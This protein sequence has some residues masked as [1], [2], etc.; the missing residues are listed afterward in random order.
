MLQLPESIVEER[1]ISMF[2]GIDWLLV[3]T[4]GLFIAGFILIGI[5]MIIPGLNAP[6]IAGTV[7]LIVAVFLLSDT[8]AEGAVITIII[9]ALLAVMFVVILGMLSKG[10]F[11]S[12]IVLKEEQKKD[13]GY[14][15]SDNMKY[16]LGK[17]GTAVTDLRPSGVGNI[18]GTDFDVISEGKY[19]VK[20]A[21]LVVYKV[22]G[23][24]IIVKE[25]E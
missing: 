4:I 13:Q 2:G 24:K 6:G 8:F 22:K 9:L 11:K 3:L 14:I 19:I 18:D 12:P 17:Q 5:E 20:G 25:Q 1:R 23:S 10:Y 21:G 16:L 7:C 15:S